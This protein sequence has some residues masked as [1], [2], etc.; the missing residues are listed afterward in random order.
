MK[1]GISFNGKWDSIHKNADS[2]SDKYRNGTAGSYSVFDS[3]FIFVRLFPLFRYLLGFYS[4]ETTEQKSGSYSVEL[5]K[6]GILLI[7]LGI[8]FNGF[9]A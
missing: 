5:I 8:L 3:R 7:F 6:K 1:S 4:V 2:Y 9:L